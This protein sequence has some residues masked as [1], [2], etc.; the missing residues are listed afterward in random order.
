MSLPSIGPDSSPGGGNVMTPKVGIIGMLIAFG[1]V[2]VGLVSLGIFGDEEPVETPGPGSSISLKPTP[3]AELAALL[4]EESLR[5]LERELG[6]WFMAEDRAPIYDGRAEDEAEWVEHLLDYRVWRRAQGLPEYVHGTIENVPDALDEPA[7]YR[8][9]VVRVWGRVEKITSVELELPSGAR[10]AW[11][12]QVVDQAGT[13]WTMT[14]LSAP[15]EA[16]QTGEWVKGYGVFVKLWPVDDFPVRA[17]HVFLS[18]E[19]VKT[20]PPVTHR[21]PKTEWLEQVKD[22]IHDPEDAKE[23]EEGPLYGMLNYV[24]QLG[25]E[26]YAELRDT[27][28]LMLETLPNALPLVDDG[29]ERFRFQPVRV[30][31]APSVRTFG[32]EGDLPENPGNIDTVYRGY[33]MDDRNRV[34]MFLSPFGKEAFDFSS[35]R[36]VDVEGFFFKRRVVEPENRDPYWMPVLIG[37][38]TTPVATEHRGVDE[39]VLITI[40]GGGSVLVFLGMLFVIY[41]N[42]QERARFESR[43]RNRKSSAGSRS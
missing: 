27:D 15:E 4:P 8:G 5:T 39:G 41:R 33:L 12:T 10:P 42:R 37:A 38:A 20:F 7:P 16:I 17:L 9:R 43:W 21:E 31:L 34:V 36:L 23:L 3:D 25:P 2:V 29:Y 40:L 24:R 35:S 19:L 18:R 11:V 32:T 13:R 1:V 6:E 26:G 22:S 30:R 28:Q 14:G